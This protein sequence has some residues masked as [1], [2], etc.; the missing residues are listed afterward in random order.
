VTAGTKT[1]KRKSGVK[2]KRRAPIKTRRRRKAIVSQVQLSRIKR[3]ISRE[4]PEFKDVQPVITERIIRPQSSLYKK[5]S[6]GVPKIARKIIRLKFTKKI[7]TIDHTEIE[8][9]LVVSLSEQG[10]I[11]KITESR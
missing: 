8:R 4:F 7:E 3:K 5:L 6:L 11:I 9:I 1:K 2:L 10:K